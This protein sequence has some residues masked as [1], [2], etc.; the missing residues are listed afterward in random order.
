[1]I[2]VPGTY[3]DSVKEAARVS[4]ENGW[5]V[6]SDTSW[7]DYDQIPLWVMQGYTIM[8]QEAP[9]VQRPFLTVVEPERA[10]CV[11]ESAQTGKA[12]TVAADAPTVIALLEC[13]E[14]SPVAWQ[15]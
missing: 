5:Q 4:R 9:R 15:D 3:D 13:Y 8:L 2:R 14:A 10:A 1:M 7:Q 11:F 6:I 12:A